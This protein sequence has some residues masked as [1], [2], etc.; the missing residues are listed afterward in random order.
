VLSPSEAARAWDAVRS[1]LPKADLVRITRIPR[2]IFGTPN[3]LGLLPAARVIPMK[4]SGIV[5]DGEPETLIKRTCSDSTAKDIA[6]RRKRLATY[7]QARFV[8]A[9]TPEEAERIFDVLLRQRRE[10]FREL[11]RFDLLD[12]PEVVAF[13]RDAALR[14]V[15][16][17]LVRIFGIEV[18]GEWIATAYGLEHGGAFHGILLAMAGET[19]KP[20]APGILIVAEIM[21]WSRRNGLTYLDFTI[22]D[23]PYKNGFRPVSRELMELAE[24]RSLRGHLVLAG[25]RGRTG[26]KAALQRHPA[27]FERLR[28][29]RQRLRR[30]GKTGWRGSGDS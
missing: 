10:R 21:E 1:V 16:D 30:F 19:W 4:A 28:E 26:A 18:N 24:A 8:E 20:V 13:Y 9:R 25:E 29:A 7:G 2:A 14:S 22:G 27:L 3:P 11:G 5:L 17:G 6:K 12:R 15:P 23:L